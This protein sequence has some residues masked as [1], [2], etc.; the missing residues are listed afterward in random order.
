MNTEAASGPYGISNLILYKLRSSLVKFLAKVFEDSMNKGLYLWKKQHM[1]R[2][3]KPGKSKSKAKSFRPVSL[4]S[5]IGKL[6]EKNYSGG[7]NRVSYQEQFTIG[8]ST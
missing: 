5:Q 8:Q 6:M 3:L 4:T 2:V 1:I 7:N